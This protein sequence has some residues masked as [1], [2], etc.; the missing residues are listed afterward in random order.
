MSLLGYVC[1]VC[2]GTEQFLS[3][4]VDGASCCGVA[5][6]FHAEC[7]SGEGSRGREA[8]K[9]GC[10]KSPEGVS[11][12]YFWHQLRRKLLHS[13]VLEQ[14]REKKED[15]ILTKLA[16]MRGRSSQPRETR[17]RA[18][19]FPNLFQKPPETGLEVAHRRI[20]CVDW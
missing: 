18:I 12:L 2:A 13:V 16:C 17:N 11:S 1:T 15:T 9:S 19:S 4:V 7:E 10:S 6:S 3:S 20:P 8:R 14:K 5:L